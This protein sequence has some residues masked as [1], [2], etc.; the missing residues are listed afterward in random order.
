MLRLMRDGVTGLNIQPL[1]SPEARATLEWAIGV[2]E[3]EIERKEDDGT[4][5]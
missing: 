2:L 4:D 3:R 1:G 5:N